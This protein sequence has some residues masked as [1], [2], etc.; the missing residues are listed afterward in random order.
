MSKASGSPGW[1]NALADDKT[2][3]HSVTQQRFAINGGVYSSLWVRAEGTGGH[4]DMQQ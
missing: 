4:L 3:N 2:T 1:V